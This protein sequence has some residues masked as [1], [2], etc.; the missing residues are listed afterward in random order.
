MNGVDVPFWS[1][2]TLENSIR[3]QWI[4][5]SDYEL[6]Y[7]QLEYES[8]SSTLFHLKPFNTSAKYVVEFHFLYKKILQFRQKHAN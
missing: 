6:G 7:Y 1:V 5:Q 8:V 3:G 2:E 4:F